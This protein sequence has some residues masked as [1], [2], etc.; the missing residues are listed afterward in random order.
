MIAG[1]GDPALPRRHLVLQSLRRLALPAF[2]LLLAGSAAAQD[3]TLDGLW[4]KLKIKIKGQTAVPDLEAPHK[5]TLTQTAYLHLTLAPADSAGDGEFPDYTATEYFYELWTETAPD[6][7]A[8]TYS[9]TE[10]LETA[11]PTNFFFSDIALNVNFLGGALVDT[12]LTAAITVKLDMEGAFKSAT[13]KSLGGEAWQG[14]TDGTDALRGGITI[15]G[16]T[17][18]VDKLPFTPK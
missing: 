2:L 6:E 14:T 7:W 1:V 16:K 4:F 3:A 9:D 17:I 10:M 5:V 18:A 11:S 15:T 13:F 8:P 12:F